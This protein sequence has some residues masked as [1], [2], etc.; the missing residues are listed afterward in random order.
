[1]QSSPLKLVDKAKVWL[2]H[3]F[4]SLVLPL[5]FL[6]VDMGS[7]I[8]AL[9]QYHKEAVG[10]ATTGSEKNATNLLCE[11]NDGTITAEFNCDA[12]SPDGISITCFPLVKYS[13]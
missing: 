1:M 9:T 13:F 7:D 11:G 6:L 10:E 8:F 2:K 4:P 12:S 3:L 5:L